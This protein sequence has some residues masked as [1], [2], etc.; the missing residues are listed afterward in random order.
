MAANMDPSTLLFMQQAAQVPP[1]QAQLMA[2]AQQPDAQGL[3][4]YLRAPQQAQQPSPA[5]AAAP[6]MF[7]DAIRPTKKEGTAK[8]ALDSYLK[9][10]ADASDPYG[11]KAAQAAA[12]GQGQAGQKQIQDSIDSIRNMPN[13]FNWSPVMAAIAGTN[14]GMDAG[15]GAA[16]HSAPM[17]ADDKAKLLANLQLS[18]GKEQIEGSKQTL[19]GI[20]GQMNFDRAMKQQALLAQHYGNEDQANA[21][22]A[23]QMGGRVQAMQDAQAQKAA[24]DFDKD[25]LIQKAVAQQNQIGI[26]RHTINSPGT[27]ITPQILDELSTGVATALSGGKSASLGATQMQRISSLQADIA[28]A[29]QY[30]EGKP[31]E[32]LSPENRAQLTSIF[33][34]LGEAYGNVAAGRATQLRQGRNFRYNDLGNQ[35]MDDKVKLYQGMGT[36]AAPTF[37]PDVLAYAT[38]YNVSPAAA[39]AMK[40]NYKGK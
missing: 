29:R 30:A 35:V 28:H 40:D 19:S 12:M 15:V 33:D 23:S 27:I 9:P 37:S 25:P 39:Q 16:E 10:Q 18:L 36:P 1:D 13:G 26:D 14:K 4:A 34:R 8:S 38:K 21:Q 31:I 24:A 32:A 7:Q 22:K 20:Q 5:V 6:H 11:Y 2:Q 17:S 3:N